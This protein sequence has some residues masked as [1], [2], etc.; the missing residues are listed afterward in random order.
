MV[1]SESRLGAAACV[2][3]ELDEPAATGWD[4]F[5]LDH[6]AGTFFHRAGWKQVI[7]RAMGHRCRYAYAERDGRIVG[8]LPL[9]HVKTALF[10]NRLVSTPFCVYGGPLATDETV[11]RAL[12]EHAIRIQDELQVDWLEFRSRERTQ[13]GWTSQGDLYSTFRKE[14]PTGEQ[15]ILKSIPRKARAVVRKAIDDDALEERTDETPD[16]FHHV[17]SVS[18]RNL[19]SPVFSRKYCRWLKQA[20]GDDCEFFVLATRGGL[21]VAGVL[22]FYFRDEILPYYGGG[23]EAAREYGAHAYMYWRLMVRAAARGVRVFDFGRSKRGT[24]A[25]SFK[26]NFGFS[27]DTLLYEYRM[28][29]GVSLPDATTLNPKYR[30]LIATWKRLPLPIA[31]AIGPFLVRRLG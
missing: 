18:V 2:I 5:V 21:P 28:K 14:I 6:P 31:N 15:E 1:G 30:S 24:G 13:P 23:T 17:Y 19:G 22:S 11:R 29:E 20:F 8:V 25:Y 16:R 7:E 9:A 4:R 3:R 26:T 27:P 10:G 12:T